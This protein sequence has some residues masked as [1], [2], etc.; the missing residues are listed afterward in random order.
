MICPVNQNYRHDEVLQVMK[1]KSLF[2]SYSQ[3]AKKWLSVLKMR[4]R[5]MNLFTC[6]SEMTKSE[7]AFLFVVKVSRCI[8]IPNQNSFSWYC[9]TQQHILA[10]Y[11]FMLPALWNIYFL[12]FGCHSCKHRQTLVTVVVSWWPSSC[13][14]HYPGSPV[15]I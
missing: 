6:E 5:L 8:C 9:D 13:P 14:F 11:L 1:V 2:S 15:T 10:Q 12:C 4:Q 7:E 3:W